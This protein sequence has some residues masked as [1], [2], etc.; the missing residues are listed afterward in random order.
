MPDNGAGTYSLPQ[1]AFVS[2]TT[3]SSSKVNSDFSDLATAMNARLA[4]NGENAPTANLPMANFRHT[5]AS[6]GVARTDYATVGQAVSGALTWGGTSTGSANAQAISPS[7][8]IGAYAAGQRFSFLAGFTNSAGWTLAVSGLAAT[9][10]LG[11]VTAGQLVEVIYDG[12]A[13]RVLTNASAAPAANLIINGGFRINQRAYTS[14]AAKAA[15]VY[16]HDRWKAGSG[17]GTYTF[18]QAAG[19]YTAVTITAGSIVQV[20]EAANVAGGAYTLAWEGTATAKLN[21]GTAAVSPITAN[22][23][24]NTNATVEFLTGTVGRVVVSNGTG[25]LQPLPITTELALCQ[26][27]YEA[28]AAY[29][30]FTSNGVNHVLY[31]MTNFAV[32]KRASPTAAQ[33]GSSLTNIASLTVGGVSAGSI[34]FAMV[35]VAAGN[36]LGI[37]NWT[38]D[39]EL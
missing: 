26:R 36:A 38:A 25:P 32:A 14:G 20:I 23:P 15:G 9:A 10:V 8:G 34:T 22:L 12:T 30:G 16:M 28:G 17:G 11:A 4:R 5:G 19:P 35:A 33:S 27:Y 3:I 29:F 39:A 6:D 7:P 13:F 24:A 1:P 21:G 2:A 37:S 31:Q 18:T